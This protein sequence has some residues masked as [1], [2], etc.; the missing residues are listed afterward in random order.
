MEHGVTKRVARHMGGAC[1]RPNDSNDAQERQRKGVVFSLPC[2]VAIPPV[3]HQARKCV[4]DSR[5][6]M[7]MADSPKETTDP[8]RRDRCNLVGL[9]HHLFMVE[10][11]NRLAFVLYDLAPEHRLPAAG[12]HRHTACYAIAEQT[13]PFGVTQ[14]VLTRRTAG[15]IL[16]A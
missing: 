2:N 11:Q 9:V 7:D 13:R 14:W 6:I 12:A 1:A 3:F 5:S 8:L 15:V 10:L 16:P 4:V